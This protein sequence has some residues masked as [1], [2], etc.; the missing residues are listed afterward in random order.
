VNLT[1]I[2]KGNNNYYTTYVLLCSLTN[3]KTAKR[4]ERGTCLI[5]RTVAAVYLIISEGNEDEGREKSD[6]AMPQT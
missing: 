5:H 4:S 6:A 3:Q 1:S 2:I